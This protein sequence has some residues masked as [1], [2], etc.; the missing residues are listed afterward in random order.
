MIVPRSLLCHAGNTHRPPLGGTSKRT[1][2]VETFEPRIVPVSRDPLAAGLNGD[3][4]GAVDNIF[5]PSLVPLV[6]GGI[7]AERV[8]CAEASIAGPL[9]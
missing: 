6:I 3:G 9:R 5:E 1:A 4:G 2:P 7:G 8:E